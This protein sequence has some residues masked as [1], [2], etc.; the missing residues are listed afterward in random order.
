M[1]GRSWLAKVAITDDCDLHWDETI[2]TSGEAY[3]TGKLGGLSFPNSIETL[4]E[5][6]TRRRPLASRQHDPPCR[7]RRSDAPTSRL[8][9]DV[10]LHEPPTPALDSLTSSQPPDRAIADNIPRAAGVRP[11]ET[12]CLQIHPFK[13]CSMALRRASRC[14]SSANASI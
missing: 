14:S 11:A 7:P 12:G 6:L 1:I 5:N 8:C 10:S 3:P 2:M 9:R 13:T 4:N